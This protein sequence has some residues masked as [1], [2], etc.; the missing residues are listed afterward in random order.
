MNLVPRR[1]KSTKDKTLDAV[2]SVAKTW[3][4]WQLA[5]SVGKGA[6]KAAKAGVIAKMAPKRKLGALALLG[7]AGVLAAKKL[8]GGSGDAPATYSPP[9]QP[10]P[11]PPGVSDPGATPGA[12]A[13]PVSPSA[14]DS[15]Q[16]SDAP[17]PPRL[18]DPPGQQSA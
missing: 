6:K 5:K 12:A 16:Q 9:V 18:P 14:T 15:T 4:E 7:G 10:P 11:M 2:A 17:D 1:Q 8:K 13:P 3:S